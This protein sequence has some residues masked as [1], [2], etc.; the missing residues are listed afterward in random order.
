MENR[1]VSLDE[2]KKQ[3]AKKQAAAENRFVL[4]EALGLTEL[5]LA[6]SFM[7]MEKQLG[8]WIYNKTRKNWFYWNASKNIWIEDT[9]SQ[10]YKA[11]AE[12]VKNLSI[13]YSYMTFDDKEWNQ[14]E[15]SL[16]KA[17]SHQGIK[18]II[19]CC[20]AVAKVIDETDLDKNPY[21]I[22]L[23][24]GIYDLQRQ[25]FH[26]KDSGYNQ[27]HLL[28]KLCNVRY[29][30]GQTCEI[31][32]KTLSDIFL[33]DAEYVDYIQRI[34]AY[35]LLGSN[36]EHAVFVFHGENGRNGKTTILNVLAEI[37]G[38]YF[39]QVP[40]RAFT[41]QGKDQELVLAELYG[42]RFALVSETERG[43]EL[44]QQLLKK[45]AGGN[46]VSGR[47]LYQSTIEYKPTYKVIIE[48]NHL[49][50]IYD[51]NATW[52]RMHTVQF[53]RYFQPH[54]RDKDLEKKLKRELC[55]IFL[56]LLEG[57]KKYLERGLAKPSKAIKHTQAH[58]NEF[59]TL[60]HF[61]GECF[62]FTENEDDFILP[63]RLFEIY[64]EWIA[65]N[66]LK[67]MN[68]L[69]FG[70]EIKKRKEITYKDSKRMMINGKPT[71]RSCYIKMKEA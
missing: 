36:D 63:Q 42:K 62:A 32:T 56:W 9:N 46:T 61:M 25:E 39:K 45:I 8:K 64:N 59:D 5:R 44:A 40:D 67:G 66:K 21:L 70:K 38:D 68:G 1:V 7:E 24:N 4:L 26:A 47:R 16:V 2:K 22:N 18:N 20:M 50:A 58:R 69:Q 6:E 11:V 15:K 23:Q 71:V 30:E 27:V 37:M 28:T 19:N 14:I 29:I 13:E 51:D 34:F 3:S 52:E 10:M 31:W 55:G 60:G 17:Q 41:H 49:P 65:K 53:E 33:N 43:A 54:E 57:W 35:M 12:Y 48:T